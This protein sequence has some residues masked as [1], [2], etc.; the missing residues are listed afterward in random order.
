WGPI[1]LAVDD[2]AV[3]ALEV[4]T[5]AEAFVANLERRLGRS[6]DLARAGQTTTLL[7][8]AVDEVAA[9]LRGARREFDLPIRLDDRPAWDRSVLGGVRQ[10]GWGSVSSYGGVARLIG[11]P[12]AARAVGGAVGRNPIGLLIPCHRVIAGDG[13]IGGYGG[14]WYGTRERLLDIKRELLAIEGVTLP[15]RIAIP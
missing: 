8:R 9:Y 5:P 4:L 14:A 13:S 11:R 1:H 15:A 7:D 3:L 6:V 12:G 10:L 2:E